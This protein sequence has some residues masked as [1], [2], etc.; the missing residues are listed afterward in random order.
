MRLDYD[1]SKSVLQ[2]DP[3]GYIELS[4]PDGSPYYIFVNGLGYDSLRLDYKAFYIS[5]KDHHSPLP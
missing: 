4:K 1:Y 5:N 2:A 3:S